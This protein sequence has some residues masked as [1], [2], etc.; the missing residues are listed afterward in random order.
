MGRTARTEPQCLYKGALYFY[1]PLVKS[2]TQIYK[3]NT[4]KQATF[5]RICHIYCSQSSSR[6]YALLQLRG[7]LTENIHRHCDN[8]G[9]EG[10]LKWVFRSGQT[11]EHRLESL[12]T[13]E[14]F[15]KRKQLQCSLAN[16]EACR[17]FTRRVVGKIGIARRFGASGEYSQWPPL[18]EIKNFIQITIIH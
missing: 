17:R 7:K 6:H 12:R 10:G 16:T 11:L 13:D 2:F 8:E 9:G 14:N 1:F 3:T 18:T 5:F 4:L 15:S